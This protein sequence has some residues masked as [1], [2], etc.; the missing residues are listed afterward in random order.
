MQMNS[1]SSVAGEAV[2]CWGVELAPHGPEGS[3]GLATPT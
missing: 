2:L 3:I 1:T